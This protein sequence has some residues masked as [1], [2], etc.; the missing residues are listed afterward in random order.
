[1]RCDYLYLKNFKL[2]LTRTRKSCSLNFKLIYFKALNFTKGFKHGETGRVFT[3]L[4]MNFYQNR[5]VICQN[6]ARYSLNL[7]PSSSSYTLLISA[8]LAFCT[9]H[10][11]L[12]II[13]PCANTTQIKKLN[14]FNIIECSLAFHLLYIATYW[15][16]A[17][18][19][20]DNFKQL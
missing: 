1:M 11:W 19:A 5:K 3:L 17:S 8:H 12:R 15:Y 2:H 10:S 7:F 4:V 13:L 9:E 14:V 20:Y 18:F 16:C 6:R